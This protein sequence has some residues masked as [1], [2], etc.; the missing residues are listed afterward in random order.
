MEFK[1]I[2][3]VDL[4][5]FYVTFLI[6]DIG[7]NDIENATARHNAVFFLYQDNKTFFSQNR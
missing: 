2:T 7:I 3:L 6:V 1:S 4:K 5:L